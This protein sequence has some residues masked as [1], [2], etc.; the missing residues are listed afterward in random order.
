[1]KFDCD[2]NNERIT[3]TFSHLQVL[4]NEDNSTRDIPS[5]SSD[6]IIVLNANYVQLLHFLP[7]PDPICESTQSS[8]SAGGYATKCKPAKLFPYKLGD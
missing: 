4:Q 8:Q 3:D 5:L 2:I 1:M 6:K 7:T